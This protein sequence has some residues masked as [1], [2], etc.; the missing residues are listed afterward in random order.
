VAV[1]D[2]WRKFAHFLEDMG[3]R[4]EGTTLDRID[5]GKGYEP[6]NCRWATRSMQN[7]NR[8]KFKR[9][10]V[11]K[12][13]VLPKSPRPRGRPP[14]GDKAATDFIR[15]RC[16]PQEKAGYRRKAKPKGLSAWLKGLADKA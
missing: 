11:R 8:G 15:F 5:N 10:K 9:G 6:G 4:P 7:A 16:T 13:V 12:A 14:L 1:C 2:R 3:A